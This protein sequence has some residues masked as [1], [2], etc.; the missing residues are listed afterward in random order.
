MKL[1]IFFKKN[2][3]FTLYFDFFCKKYISNYNLQ[4]KL[5]YILIFISEILQI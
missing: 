3:W 2:N 1:Q 4:L 5:S